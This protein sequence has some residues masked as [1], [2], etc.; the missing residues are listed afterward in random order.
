MAALT[1]GCG[2]AQAAPRCWGSKGAGALSWGKPEGGDAAIELFPCLPVCAG[3][4]AAVGRLPASTI[5]ALKPQKTCASVALH[6]TERRQLQGHGHHLVGS[7][8]SPCSRMRLA[9]LVRAPL[10][11]FI[12]GYGLW[13]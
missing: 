5:T 3:R 10:L 11:Y 13:G 12:L 2:A 7:V 1:S 8:P 9:L 4:E 6:G